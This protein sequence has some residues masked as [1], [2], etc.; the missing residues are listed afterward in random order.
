M[1]ARGMVGGGTLVAALVVVFVCGGAAFGQ[2]DPSKKG[3][4]SGPAVQYDV[5]PPLSVMA[6]GVAP[7]P[8]KKEKKEKKKAGRIPLPG[9]ST[10]ATDPALQSSLGTAAAPTA[11][12]NFEGVGQGSCIASR[13]QAAGPAILNQIDG[14]ARRRGDHG[15]SRHHRLDDHLS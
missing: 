8:D 9:V 6:A 1:K 5:S 15:L 11:G 7:A 13:H 2:N 3:D 10:A 4:D 14:S 12:L